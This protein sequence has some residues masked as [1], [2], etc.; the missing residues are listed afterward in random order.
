MF[1]EFL[2][3][4]AHPLFLHSA[5]V[6]V[7]LLAVLSVLYAFVP[8]VRQHTRWV[9]GVL[10]VVAPSAAYLTKESGDAFFDRLKRLNQVSDEYIPR[11]QEHQDLGTNT[12]YASIGLG[13]VTLA[14]VYFVAPRAAAASAAG[15]GGSAGSA[16]AV[17]LALAALTVIAAGI[18]LYYVY[19]TGDTGAKAVWEGS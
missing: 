19:R 8:L 2:G 11:L 13:V 7:P 9:V 12:L 10:A 6:F 17:A 3:L 5:V 14:L 1:E 18:S 4:P 16:R 15:T